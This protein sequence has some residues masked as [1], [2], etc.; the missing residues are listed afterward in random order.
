VHPL[1]RILNKDTRLAIGLISGTSMDGIDAALVQIKGRGEST[2]IDLIHFAMLPYPDLLRD[3]LLALSQPG[4]G[5]VDH[6]CQMNFIVGEYF[7]DAALEI[8]KQAGV[9]HRQ[10]DFIGSH[11]QTVHHLPDPCYMFGKWSRSTLQIGDPSVIANRTGIATVANF[12]GADMAVNGQGAPLVPYFDYLLFQSTEKNR[13]VLNLGGI[14]NYTI[15]KKGGSKTEVIAYDT[16]PA[17]MVIDALMKRLFHLDYDEDGAVALRGIASE[18]VL[19]ELKRHDYF[20][21]TIPKSTGR[22]EF[23]NTF[24]LKLLEHADKFGITADDIVATA[25]ELSAWAIA[26]ALKFSTVR[27][28]DVDELIVSGGGVHN[29][30]MMASLKRKFVNSQVLMTHE[31]GIPV[32]AKEAICFAVLA[33]ET[34]SG[35]PSN[36]PAVTGANR[37][38][39]LGTISFA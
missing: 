15:L 22:E 3:T 32:D 37:S 14:A 5:T 4:N 12:R 20:S 8:C 35:N 24:V 21:K 33:N 13:V 11:G 9:D 25:T 7:A 36:L 34:I 17:N 19:D 1:V 26:D 10:I 16:G 31:F 18:Q 38:V 23:G 27:L 2:S 39:I 28:N 29:Q 30:A 6:I